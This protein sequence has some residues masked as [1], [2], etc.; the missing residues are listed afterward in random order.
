MVKSF[1]SLKMRL[2]KIRYH[3]FR[4]NLLHGRNSLDEEHR[5][6]RKLVVLNG[7]SEPNALKTLGLL[8]RP[9]RGRKLFS[10]L[11][12]LWFKNNL[13]SLRDLVLFYNRR[14]TAPLLKAIWKLQKVFSQSLHLGGFIHQHLTISQMAYQ[15][16]LRNN[17]TKFHYHL[18]NRKL[19]IGMKHTLQGGACCVYTRRSCQNQTLVRAKDVVENETPIGHAILCKDICSFD[20]TSH[21][22]SFSLKNLS[23]IFN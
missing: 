4:D 22:V 15:Y 19:Y 20:V 7:Q 3:H 10:N 12:R 2:A 17:A 6:F 9:L 21:Y 1:Q 16:F 14:D 5:K 18:L 11:Q 13:L 23:K 8:K